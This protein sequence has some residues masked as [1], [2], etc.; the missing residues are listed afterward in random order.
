MTNNELGTYMFGGFICHN[1]YST[2]YQDVNGLQLTIKSNI[3]RIKVGIVLNITMW[4][5]QQYVGFLLNKSDN[6]V[7]YELPLK[8]LMREHPEDNL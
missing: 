7:T 5:Y 2:F 1:L 4:D 8:N 6:F 3:D